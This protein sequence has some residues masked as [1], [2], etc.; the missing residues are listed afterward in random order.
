MK[1]DTRAE[2][3]EEIMKCL[4]KRFSLTNQ[5]TS[6][7]KSFIAKIGYLAEKPGAEMVLNGDIP[8]EWK[9]NKDL[10]LFLS[11]LKY[12]KTR[13]YIAEKIDTK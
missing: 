7:S 11:L 6:M 9:K 5:C 8:N 10:E 13:E 4:T 1:V 2:V 12:P 3:E